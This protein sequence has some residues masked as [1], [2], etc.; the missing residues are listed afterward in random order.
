MKLF[1]LQAELHSSILGAAY[2]IAKFVDVIAMVEVPK[3]RRI[4]TEAA[5]QI[6]VALNKHQKASPHVLAIFPANQHCSTLVLDFTTATASLHNE[7]ESDDEDDYQ[8]ARDTIHEQKVR[9][10]IVSIIFIYNP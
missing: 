2:Q 1:S 6:T 3:E 4:T 5:A 8:E 9:L 7:S 10:I